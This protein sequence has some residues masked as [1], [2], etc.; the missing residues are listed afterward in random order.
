MIELTLD[1][2]PLVENLGD[3]IAEQINA[4]YPDR[5]IVRTIRYYDAYLVPSQSFP[6]LKVFRESQREEADNP[7]QTVNINIAYCLNMVD[8]DIQA[9][10]STYITRQI[11]DAV[12]RYALEFKCFKLIGEFSS[13]YRSLYQMGEFIHQSDINITV[14]L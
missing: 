8:I 1:T 3:Y 4:A 13:R 12:K 9:G 14:R 11:I 10:I 7:L 2:D 5:E 6:L